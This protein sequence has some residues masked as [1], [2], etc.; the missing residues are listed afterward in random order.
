[1]V[2]G[3]TGGVVA[4]CERDYDSGV[5][6]E[7][8]VELSNWSA[9]HTCKPRHLYT[10]DSTQDVLKLLTTSSRQRDRLRVVGTGLSPNGIG[11]ASNGGDMVSL[12]NLD[13]IKI[14]KSRMHVRVGAGATVRQVLDA[15]AA[16]GLT[17]ENFSSIQEQQI[18]GWTQVAAHG[19]GCSLPTVEEQ[20][21]SLKLASPG[22]G[23]LTL[24]HDSDPWLFNMAKVGLGA[25]GIITEVTLKVIPRMELREKTY[26]L[27]SPSDVLRGHSQRL[28]DHRHCR[29][30]WVPGT[31]STVVV[32]SNPTTTQ[33]HSKAQSAAFIIIMHTS[34]LTLE[35]R[36]VLCT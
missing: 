35:C 23:L 11:L 1:M 22:G 24:S 20:I 3:L 15:L 25:L 16:E 5:T 4:F 31:G 28:R 29:Y 9:T 27:D 6:F 8:D 17:L 18:G 10:P 13:H 36:K 19:T 21:V 34:S 14:D 32:V 33:K 7:T 30:M 12:A 26:V 2:V